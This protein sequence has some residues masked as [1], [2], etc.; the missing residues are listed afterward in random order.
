MNTPEFCANDG[1][2][3]CAKFHEDPSGCE[4]LL[5]KFE[6]QLHDLNEQW[7]SS[8]DEMEQALLQEQMAKVI[9]KID[10]VL[11]AKNANAKPT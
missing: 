7:E 3:S 11:E 10:I 8:T 5:D 1:T 4:N 6:A 9:A 2:C